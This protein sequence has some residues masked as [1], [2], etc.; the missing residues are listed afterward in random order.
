MRRCLLLLL[1]YTARAARIA[2][3]AAAAVTTT[4]AIFSVYDM[5]ASLAIHSSNK[6]SRCKLC[7]SISDGSCKRGVSSAYFGR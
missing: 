2:T 3:M 5:D 7:H 6:E 4:N 1:L